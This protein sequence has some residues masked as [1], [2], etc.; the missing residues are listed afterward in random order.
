[1]YARVQLT[2][3]R[4]FM[5]PFQKLQFTLFCIIAPLGSLYSQIPEGDFKTPI[6]YAAALRNAVERD[7]Q[8]SGIEAILAAADKCTKRT[9][10]A[11]RQCDLVAWR[12]EG[13]R[14]SLRGG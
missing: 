7:P 6:N 9:S 1:M 3:I 8:L 11:Q 2:I 5:H 10:L 12:H 14:F 13:Q 4:I